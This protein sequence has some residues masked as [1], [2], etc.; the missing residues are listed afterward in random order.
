MENALK[1]YQ[2]IMHF[3]HK[4]ILTMGALIMGLTVC[5]IALEAFGRYLV[6]SSRAF[7]VEIPRLLIPLLV[8]PMMGVLMRLDK[9]IKVDVF[10]AKLTGAKKS[11]LI[12]LAYSVVLAVSVQFFLSGISA[13][14]FFYSMGLETHTEIIFP[15]WVTYLPFP[16]GFGLLILF[17]WELLCQELFSLIRLISKERP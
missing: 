1:N 15:V 6:G 16:A 17:V 13:V 3:L 2:K 9:H 10:S 11:L 12:I 8:F 4:G 5:S 14:G 7:M